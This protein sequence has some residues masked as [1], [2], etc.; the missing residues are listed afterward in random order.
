ML[1]QRMMKAKSACEFAPRHVFTAFQFAAE[2]A[3]ATEEWE[4]DAACDIV[5]SANRKLAIESRK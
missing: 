1:T 2:T 5:V 3:A 4:M